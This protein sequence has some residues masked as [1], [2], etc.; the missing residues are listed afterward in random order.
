[1]IYVISMAM[2]QALCQRG[3]RLLKSRRTGIHTIQFIKSSE[4][5]N[6]FTA[7]EVC[8]LDLG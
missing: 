4:I 2:I 6:L 5:F 3:L 1:M 7:F 8:V